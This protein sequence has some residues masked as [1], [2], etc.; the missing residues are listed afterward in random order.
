MKCKQHFLIRMPK[1]NKGY[2]RI[3]KF[4]VEINGNDSKE[5]ALIK[6]NCGI[7]IW[8]LGFIKSSK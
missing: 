8:F 3:K 7:K 6:E 1:A 5:R 4:E 2:K